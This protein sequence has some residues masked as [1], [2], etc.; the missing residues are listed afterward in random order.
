MGQIEMTSYNE[1]YIPTGW[2][3]KTEI[4]PNNPI[5][6]TTPEVELYDDNV[7]DLWITTDNKIED[8]LL[9]C[10]EKLI[11]CFTHENNEIVL[12]EEIS[13]SPKERAD[14]KK[15]NIDNSGKIKERTYLLIVKDNDT[16]ST[17]YYDVK[18]ARVEL[19]KKAKNTNEDSNSL[20][21]DLE[22]IAVYDEDDENPF[23]I[24]FEDSVK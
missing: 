5:R 20:S 7:F 15:E 12:T 3:K 11:L 19:E 17:M 22:V 2:A 18:L 1:V 6:S 21:E 16:K 13:Y 8:D 24:E 10:D 23:D 9:N 14:D 4:V